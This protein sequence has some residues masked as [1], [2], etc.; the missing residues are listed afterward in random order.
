MTERYKHVD[1]LKGD[2]VLVIGGSSGVGYGIAEACVEYGCVVF[3][4]ASTSESAQK[5]L[6]KITKRYGEAVRDRVFATFCNLSDEDSLDENLAKLFADA[7][8][9]GKLDHII[10][11]AGDAIVP[12]QVQD[13]SVPAIRRAG[14]VRFV[15]PLLVAKYAATH[16]SPGPKSSYTITSGGV[17]QRPT[18]NWSVPSSYLAGIHG[19]ARSLALD[20][21]PVR[22]N[23]VVLGAVDTEMWNMDEDQKQQ[24]FSTI[25]SKSAT[26]TIGKVE[27][28]AETYV[29]ILKDRNCTASVVNSNGGYLIM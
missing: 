26:G 18:P 3:I 21:R 12:L 17:S 28:V 4:S 6:S 29:G 20:L 8:G 10:F 19:M 2:R 23:A 7:S 11:T 25:G 15:A 1:K 27:D 14:L 13:I 5:A 24:F 9:G 22:V 16:L